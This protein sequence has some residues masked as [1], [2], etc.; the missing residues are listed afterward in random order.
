VG[1]QVLDFELDETI[2]PAADKVDSV[3]CLPLEVVELLVL[4]LE[5]PD[6][7]ELMVELLVV[8]VQHSG[9]EGQSRTSNCEDAHRQYLFHDKHFST[10]VINSR[11]L[12]YSKNKGNTI[13]IRG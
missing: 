10:M 4:A 11:K 9:L 3:Q 13:N 7:F 6:L 5:L 8:R 2:D 12:L 1:E